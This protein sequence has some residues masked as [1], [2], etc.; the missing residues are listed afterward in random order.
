MTD[1]VSEHTVLVAYLSEHGSTA[2]I[3]ERLAATMRERGLHVRVAAIADDPDPELFEAVVLG[4]AVHN[5]DV[6]PGFWAF[7]GRHRGA[8]WSKPTWVFTVGVG[9]AA[10]GP[11]RRLLSGIGKAPMARIRAI[12]TLVDYRAF[13][14]VFPPS[15]NPVIRL[16]MRLVGYPSGDLRDWVEIGQWANRIADHID[17]VL[18]PTYFPEPR[19]TEGIAVVESPRSAPS[20]ADQ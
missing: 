9:P 7:T 5:R 13:A 17:A 18:T 4:S 3:A 12:V 8:L 19:P 2:E 6:L 1:H 20:A 11:L 15:A 14:G 10:T 16:V